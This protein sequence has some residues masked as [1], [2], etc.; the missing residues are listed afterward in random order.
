MGQDLEGVGGQCGDGEE[1]SDAS[2]RLRV[3][4][5]I[6]ASESSMIRVC[7]HRDVS[8][9]ITPNLS[10]IICEVSIQLCKYN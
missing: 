1:I 2:K 8:S 7:E 9:G 4:S 6:V 3:V 5:Q 10:V